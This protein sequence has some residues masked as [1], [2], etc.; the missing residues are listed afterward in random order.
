VELPL[1]SPTAK[2]QQGKLTMRVQDPNSTS[3]PQIATTQPQR[4][5]TAPDA[6]SDNQS[7]LKRETRDSPQKSGD[8]V[9]KIRAITASN[10]ANV[11]LIG[12]NDPFVTLKV[13]DFFQGKTSTS[14]ETGSSAQWTYADSDA[15]QMVICTNLENLSKASMEVEVYDENTKFRSNVL[16]G[17]GEIRLDVI[18][19]QLNAAGGCEMKLSSPIVDLKGKTSGNVDIT[20]GVQMAPTAG[21]ARTQS[22][23]K[24]LSATSNEI[25]ATPISNKSPAT[26]E[27]DAGTMKITRISC[28]DLKNVEKMSGFGDQNDPYVRISYGS[29]VGRTEAIDGGGSNPKWEYLDFALD[30]T[31]DQVKFEN[32][33]VQV[34]D[35]NISGDVMIGEGEALMFSLASSD[36]IGKESEISVS[37]K[38]QK[39]NITGRVVLAVTLKPLEKTESTELKIAPGFVRGVLNVFR[40]ATFDLKN[41][42]LMGKQDPYVKLLHG[43]SVPFKTV[44]KQDAGSTA[45]WDFLDFK[46][47]V[48]VDTLSKNPL[49]IEVWD[50][51]VSK[52]RLIGTAEI[53]VTKAATAIGQEFEFPASLVG[54]DGKSQA[55][56][57]VIFCK[58]TEETAKVD[59]SSH[60]EIP[61]NLSGLLRIK[62]LTLSGVKNTEIVG[63]QVRYSIIRFN[64]LN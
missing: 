53:N 8:I 54:K 19:S 26:T 52:D 21:E 11:E 23:D 20:I 29:W 25:F 40:I 49:H 24:A 63:Q 51:N 47:I 41:T 46:N 15:S 60:V 58:I 48:T 2:R 33:R 27:F 5:I 1:F 45:M 17:K 50:S 37:I 43:Q 13:S 57:A 31:A 38:D 14:H 55:G 4:S 39:Q 3:N 12:K 22:S 42:E 61:D 32:L 28:F 64:S 10:L 16:I 9:L 36:K 56:R 18:K 6:I 34:F 7:A 59:E 62:R 44:V 35:K 30:V